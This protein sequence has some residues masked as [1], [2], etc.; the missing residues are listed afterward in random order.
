MIVHYYGVL[1][2]YIP[3]PSF[4]WKILNFMAENR[5]MITLEIM[6]S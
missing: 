4:V 1:S 5:F 6:M 3:I 2:N